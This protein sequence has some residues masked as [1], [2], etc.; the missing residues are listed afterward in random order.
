MIHPYFQELYIQIFAF[1]SLFNLE[2]ILV[3]GMKYKPNCIFFKYRNTINLKV[4]LSPKDMNTI[5]FM[6]AKSL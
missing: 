6:L 5:F 4:E 1:R 2:F 3:H